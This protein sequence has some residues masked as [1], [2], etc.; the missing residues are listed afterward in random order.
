MPHLE[1]NVLPVRN[2]AKVAV[3]SAFCLL[4]SALSLR[5]A[6]PSLT[7]GGASGA[8]GSAVTIPITFDPGTASVAGI[9]FNIVLPSALSS[10]TVTPG[11]IV[12][13]AGKNVST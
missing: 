1:A 3:I 4:L 5:A 2:T 12:T 10:G 6:T 13:S 9:Q 11:A 8:A 7:V